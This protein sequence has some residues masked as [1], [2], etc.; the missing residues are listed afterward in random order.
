MMKVTSAQD[1]IKNDLFKCIHKAKFEY[2]LFPIT[3]F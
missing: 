3:A 1:F 2:Y